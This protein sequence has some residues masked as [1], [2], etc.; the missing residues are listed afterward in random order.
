MMGILDPPMALGLFLPR[1]VA[2]IKYLLLV[3]IV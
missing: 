1:A 2:Y 3:I